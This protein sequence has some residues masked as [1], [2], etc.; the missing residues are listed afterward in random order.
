MTSSLTVADLA[1]C[2]EGAIPAV[3]ATASADGT[4]NVTYL[5][6]AHVVG[7]DRIA[8]SNQFL[9]K[10]ARN[11]AENPRASLLLLDPH[12][13][14]EYRLTI[15]YERT[16]LRPPQRLYTIEE[17]IDLLG[18]DRADFELPE[19]DDGEHDPPVASPGLDGFVHHVC[20]RCGQTLLV[21]PL[22]NAAERLAGES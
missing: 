16:E 21:E 20:P 4:P 17:V 7:D 10:S 9:S 1:R 13:H 6:K 2:F 22:R 18:F 5:S 8:L 12:T 19:C 11:L 14:D 15:V 3:I